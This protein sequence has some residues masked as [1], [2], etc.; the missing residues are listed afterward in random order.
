MPHTFTHNG[1]TYDVS[2]IIELSKNLP[3]EKLLVQDLKKYLELQCW[4]DVTKN[5][6]ENISALE[7]YSRRNENSEF[8]AHVERA[9]N[10][11]L[12]YPIIIN[13]EIPMISDGM[14]RLLKA[15]IL[16]KK[17]IKTVTFEKMPP[18]AVV[19]E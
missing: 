4:S 16:K 19:T 10:S 7:V 12:K 8:K 3:V 14:H 6:E 2:K 15:S 17:Y 9:M 5:K 18:E 11:D 13:G 1:V